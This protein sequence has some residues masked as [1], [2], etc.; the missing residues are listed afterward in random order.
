MVSPETNEHNE[1]D[2][3]LNDIDFNDINFDDINF[4]DIDFDEEYED[5]FEYED[6]DE[7]TLN[8]ISDVNLNYESE[9]R[10]QKLELMKS[11]KKEW[12]IKEKA[13][14]KTRTRLVKFF[15]GILCSQ[16]LFTA[17]I[18]TFSGIQDN[19]FTVPDA[20]ITVIAGS[21]IA[22]IIGVFLIIAKFMFDNQNDKLLD[23]I[24]KIIGKH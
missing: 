16:L 22:E 11:L 9:M 10:A 6:I 7:M 21:L 17:I 3:V 4:D 23:I 18:V 5:L 20:V 15:S 13:K 2:V 19:N 1:E 24:E 12:K 14:S 8:E